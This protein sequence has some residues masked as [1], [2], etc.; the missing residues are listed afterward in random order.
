MFKIPAK[1]Q[2]WEISSPQ[3][4]AIMNITPD[5]FFEK[6][7]VQSIDIALDIAAKFIQEGATIIDIGGQSTRPGAA[8][9]ST[10]EEIQKI[11]PIIEAIHSKFPEICISVDTFNSQVAMEGLKAGAH[12]INDISCGQF[13][14][15]MFKVVTEFNAGYIGM[16]LTGDKEN[17]H[18]IPTR[19]NIMEELIAYFQQKKKLLS[20]FGIEQW[21]IDPGFGFGKTI[22]ENFTIVKQLNDLCFLNLPI[23]LGVSRKS[24]IYKSLETSAEDAL[25]GTTIV[26]TIGLKNGAHILRV[27]DV[28]EAKEIVTL[29]PQLV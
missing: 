7:S 24:S 17:R 11:V 27:H 3:I 21:V 20:S 6:S 4:M 8:F 2:I 25:N 16:H 12:I 28:K 5:S 22:E 1:G 18:I 14:E 26:N 23:L 13:D 15:N 29:L 10:E 19:S 9:I